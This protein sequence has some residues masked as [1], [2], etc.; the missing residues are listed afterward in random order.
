L[1]ANLFFLILQLLL[2]L[3]TTEQNYSFILNHQPTIAF[4][5]FICS[6][7][8]VLPLLYLG[9]SILLKR[10]KFSNERVIFIANVLLIF[11]FSFFYFFLGSAR[12]LI[13]HFSPF[14]ATLFSLISLSLYFIALYICYYS[15]EYIRN[16]NKAFKQAWLSIRFILPFIIPF[17]CLNFFKDLSSFFPIKNL[18]DFFDLS[19]NGVGASLFYVTLNIAI[20]CIILIFLPS[21]AVLIWKCPSLQEGELK[22]KLDNLCQRAH[23]KH[24]GFRIWNIMNHSMTAAIIGIISRFRYILFTQKLLDHVPKRSVIAILAHEIGH[25]YHHHLF[26]YPFILMG[27]IIS[28]SLCYDFIFMPFL[29]LIKSENIL[30][31]FVPLLSFLLFGA[32]MAIYFRFVFGYFSRLF[33]RQADLHIFKLHC[34][35]NDMIDALDLLGKWGGNIHLNP[36]WHHHSIQQRMDFLKEA[37]NDRSLIKKHT[38]LVQRSLLAYFIIF[39]VCCGLL[40]W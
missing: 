23:F 24:A 26:I 33:E 4:A 27:M 35:A 13:H 3:I 11:F 17:I 37:N 34:E 30:F 36:N 29:A 8:L 6:Y 31:L 14:F 21:L 40:F 10:W 39:A 18:F 22:S 2:I 32:I 15:L 9:S 1:F 7:L 5:I 19:E 25:N 28:A 12:F 38:I 20:I 16:K